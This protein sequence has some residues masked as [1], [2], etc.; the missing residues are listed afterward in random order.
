MDAHV[1]FKITEGSL[2]SKVDSSPKR[3][4]DLYEML[5]PFEKEFKKLK[6][7][8]K[9]DDQYKN[10]V[11]EIILRYMVEWKDPIAAVKKYPEAAVETIMS[12][13]QAAKII[14]KTLVVD[15]IKLKPSYSYKPKEV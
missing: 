6:A 5:K 14:D 15:L 4:V 12:P 13:A 3:I 9:D 7:K 10:Q 11:K 2:L 1:Q 8:I